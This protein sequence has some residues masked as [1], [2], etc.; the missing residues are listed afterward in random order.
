MTLNPK[1]I[2][3]Y[4]GT[5]KDEVALEDFWLLNLETVTW[6]QVTNIKGSFPPKVGCTITSFPSE[7]LAF[8]GEFGE[9]ENSQY[10]NDVFSLRLEG[11]N[12]GEEPLGLS[13]EQI[14]VIGARP[15]MRTGHCAVNYKNRLLI[16]VGGEGM[17]SNKT[18]VLYNDL[19]AYNVK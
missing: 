15:T 1:T 2:L 12:F 9:N 6:R 18:P 8:G 3:F 16:V 14:E 13:I 7:L 4:G 11:E 10:T 5:D 17:S 19:W